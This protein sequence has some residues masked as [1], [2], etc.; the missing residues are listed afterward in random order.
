MFNQKNKI[1]SINLSLNDI[2]TLLNKLIIIFLIKDNI[3][4]VVDDESEMG[5]FMKFNNKMKNINFTRS[6]KIILSKKFEE[7][8]L[9]FIEF[10]GFKNI[11][12]FE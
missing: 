11:F 7:N 2:E 8:F 4:N 9:K 10:N 3:N 5:T 1:N 12:F 6:F